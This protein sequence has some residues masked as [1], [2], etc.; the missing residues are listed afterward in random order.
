[1]I[2]YPKLRVIKSTVNKMTESNMVTA[3]FLNQSIFL[4]IVKALSRHDLIWIIFLNF[5]TKIIK[6]KI[7]MNIL[8]KLL[9]NIE[10]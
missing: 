1:M 3:S 6:I 7:V 4:A 2:G 10:I 5:Y 8:I 9:K